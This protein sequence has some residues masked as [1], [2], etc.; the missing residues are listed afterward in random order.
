MRSAFPIAVAAALCLTPAAL[1]QQFE[2]AVVKPHA[3][4]AGSVDELVS[5]Y[6][7]GRVVIRGLPLKTIITI[8]FNAGYWQISGGEGWVEKDVYDV[9]ARPAQDP[10]NDAFSLRHTRFGIEDER[11]RRMLQSLLTDRFQLKL[12]PETKEGPVYL[13]QKSGK[14][15]RPVPTKYTTD[16]PAQG[17]PGYSGEIEFTGGHWFLFDASMPQLAKFVSDYGLHRPVI[18]QTGL[19]GSFDYREPGADIP[20]EGDFVS[21]IPI[22]VQELGLRL[23]ATKGP[24]ETFVID[25]AEKPSPN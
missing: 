18:D 20:Q 25:H 10:R 5:V 4:Q 13:L 15:V 2:V 14:T 24:V 22:L 3:P 17:Q 21:S 9:E 8:A 16:Q 11:L 12:R 23:V 1:P 6:P 19:T 7:G